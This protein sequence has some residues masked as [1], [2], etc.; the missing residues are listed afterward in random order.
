MGLSSDPAFKRAGG[1]D[2]RIA[3][4]LD[5]CREQGLSLPI[6]ICD[7]PRIKH[8]WDS[9]RTAFLNVTPPRHIGCAQVA[10]SAGLFLALQG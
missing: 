9:R 8:A 3:C 4:F 5:R 10:V 7:D 1:N 2:P 6:S